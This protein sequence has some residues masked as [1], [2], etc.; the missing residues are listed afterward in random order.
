ME[1]T[2]GTTFCSGA[3]QNFCR[4]AVAQMNSAIN[5]DKALEVKY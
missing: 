2:I 1:V 4:D 5:E 3:W